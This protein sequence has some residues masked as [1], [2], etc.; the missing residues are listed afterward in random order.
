M[1]GEIIMKDEQMCTVINNNFLS[2]FTKEDVDSVPI[3]QQTW[4][5]KGQ[6]TRYYNQTEYGSKKIRGFKNK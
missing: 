6:T 3:P 5:R 2:V 4:D 1:R